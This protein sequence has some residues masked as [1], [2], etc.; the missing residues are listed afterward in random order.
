M[1]SCDL[2]LEQHDSGLQEISELWAELLQHN[3]KIDMSIAVVRN[4]M[5]AG[6][7]AIELDLNY[8][9]SKVIN[10]E[11]NTICSLATSTGLML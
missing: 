2:T 5:S 11:H 1:Y 3:K 10:T 6:E 7:L 8:V 4:E 9:K